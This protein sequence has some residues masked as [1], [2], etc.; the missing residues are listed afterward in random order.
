MSNDCATILEVQGMSCPSCV[1]HINAA[2]GAIAG[3]ANVEVQLQA[4]LVVVKH[5]PTQ[6]PIAQLIETLVEE[7]YVSKQRTL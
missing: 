7:G 6:A 1:R 5:D 2:L 3:V 4:G